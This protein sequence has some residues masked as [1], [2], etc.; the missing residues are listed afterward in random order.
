SRRTAPGGE[1]L[2]RYRRSHE[3]YRRVAFCVGRARLSRRR[4]AR[5]ERGNQNRIA[6]RRSH[7]GAVKRRHNR[8]R[9]RPSWNRSRFST[10]G[11]KSRETRSHDYEPEFPEARTASGDPR[12]SR[13]LVAALR[14]LV[15][16]APR[17][18]LSLSFSAAAFAVLAAVA[19]A[20]DSV[21]PLDLPMAPASV[22]AAGFPSA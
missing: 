5:G 10:R 19:L 12:Q 8:S 17:L 21:M 11:T 6:L 18:T 15:R 13:D 16:P 4:R 22:W 7:R 2:H 20:S 3:R 1:R 9:P 14:R